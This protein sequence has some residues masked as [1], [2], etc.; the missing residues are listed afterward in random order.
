MIK[1]SVDMPREQA[2]RWATHPTFRAAGGAYAVPPKPM[3]V[4]RRRAMKRT[5]TS[6]GHDTGTRLLGEGS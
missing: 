5:G 4:G 3:A 1:K 6:M 2:S